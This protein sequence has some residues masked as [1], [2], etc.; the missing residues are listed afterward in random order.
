M[1]KIISIL[2]VISAVLFATA[3]QF[4]AIDPKIAAI[5]TLIGTVAT[6]AT[7]A[8]VRFGVSNIY[9]TIVGVAIAVLSV[10][11]GATDLL[12]ANIVTV[13]T[14]A[15]TAIA[16]F[17]KSLFGLGDDDDDDE[18]PIIP[19]RGWGD[20]GLAILLIPTLAISLSACNG[21]K[22]YV[23]TLNRV[24]GYVNTGLTM[25]EYQVDRKQI[26]NEAAL[27]ITS[28]LTTVNTINGEL[29]VES[30]K[31]VSADG[32]TLTLNQEGKS[33]LLAIVTA[34]QNVSTSLLLN[35][36]FLALPEGQRMKYVS[37]IR[38]LTATVD[39]LSQLIN[40]VK[41]EGGK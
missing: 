22:E 30:K 5:L 41:V 28:A 17:G 26:S 9:I 18:N 29:I 6:A 38:E 34:S 21:S 15:G 8:L 25:V 24:S 40:A 23:K 27:A 32:K 39:V 31:Y 37:L 7:G 14:I 36:A 12:P 13:L 20:T 33:K 11:G 16:A 35:P 2:G 1:Q 4:S 10:L 3:P 19:S